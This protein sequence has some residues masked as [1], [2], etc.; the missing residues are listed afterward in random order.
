MMT[1]IRLSGVCLLPFTFVCLRFNPRFPLR[2][3]LGFHVCYSVTPLL[4]LGVGTILLEKWVVFV[5]YS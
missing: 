1:I 2:Y 3:C 5:T 4:Q